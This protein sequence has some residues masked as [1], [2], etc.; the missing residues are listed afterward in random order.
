MRVISFAEFPYLL[1]TNIKRLNMCLCVSRVQVVVWLENIFC[2]VT[3]QRYLF[4]HS[5]PNNK[6]YSKLI[7]LLYSYE[8]TSVC[9][10]VSIERRW[11][12][13]TFRYGYLV[14]T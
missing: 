5:K 10:I 14:T 12:S 4:G 7:L 3:L 6:L 9:S 1:L 8:H 2:S 13:R 11:S